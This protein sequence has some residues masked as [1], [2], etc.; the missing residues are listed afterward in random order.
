VDHVG[1]IP[2]LIKEGF[3]GEI[4]STAETKSI[5]ELL[6]LDAAKISAYEDNALYTATDVATAL[7]QWHTL[8]YHEVKDFSSFKVETFDAGHV[9]GSS[10]YK[11]STEKG[12]MLFTGDIGNSPSPILKD[13]EFVE[14]INYLLMESVYGDRN[15]E[16]KPLRDKLFEDTL[17][18]ALTN[19]GAVLIPAFSLERT[20]VL[21]YE[22][23]NLLSE[24]KFLRYPF[25]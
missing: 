13:H 1:L 19:G 3:K 8:K 14:G 7:S 16:P 2:K 9:L 4:Y 20:Q 6:M 17:R 22:L 23:D 25:I 12:S 21:L 18:E 5:A 15:H 11:F 10:M 24:K